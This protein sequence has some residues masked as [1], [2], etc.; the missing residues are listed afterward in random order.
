MKTTSSAIPTSLRTPRNDVPSVFLNRGV[1]FRHTLKWGVLAAAV[2][3]LGAVAAFTMGSRGGA[4]TV[5]ALADRREPAMPVK[6]VALEPASF[7][8]IKRTFTGEVRASRTSEVGF[9]LSGTVTA[10]LVDEGDRVTAG[11]LMARIDTQRLSADAARVDAVLQEAKARLDELV[12]GPRQETI[13]AARARMQEV[14]ADLALL[15][16]KQAKRIRLLETGAATQEEK[17]DAD[18]AV[19]AA[20]ARLQRFKSE[21][22]ELKTGTRREQID[23]QRAVVRRLNAELDEIRVDLSKCELL[24]P[25]DATIAIR[26]LDEGEVVQAGQ[27]VLRLVEDEQLEA[28]VGVGPFMAAELSVGDPLTLRYLGRPIEC[29]VKSVLPEIDPV[30][31]T[32]SLLLRLPSTSASWI[33]PGAIVKLAAERR[34]PAD[35]YWIPTASLVRA[36]R[37]LWALYEVVD[38]NGRSLVRRTAV[39]VLHT[40]AHR[41]FIRG[42]I[43][44]KAQIIADGVHRVTPGQVVAPTASSARSSHDRADSQESA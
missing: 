22:E 27:A 29:E 10:L 9:D 33:Q 13:D 21:W 25:Y 15:Q 12:E 8:G 14:E 11:Q 4:G 43:T 5:D 39:E 30:T 44:E 26:R 32:R 6:T 23:A 31:R 19:A 1:T 28:V 36:E 7:Y 42:A 35:G 18:T 41:S 16:R 37:G 20:E 2:I 38:G 24:A 3:G 40:D 34:V 17:D